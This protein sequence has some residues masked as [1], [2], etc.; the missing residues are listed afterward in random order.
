MVSATWQRACMSR[1]V[2]GLRRDATTH[3]NAAAGKAALDSPQA[4]AVIEDMPNFVDMDNFILSVTNEI[5]L[6][7]PVSATQAA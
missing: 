3:D 4:K 5:T 2:I 1:E 6:I 7:E